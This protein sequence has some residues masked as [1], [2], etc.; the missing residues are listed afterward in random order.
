MEI[1]KLIE[2]AEGRLL[3]IEYLLVKAVLR[4]KDLLTLIRQGKNTTFLKG[5]H[6]R[7]QN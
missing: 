7:S 6:G 2:L 5:L 1:A 3:I 4:L